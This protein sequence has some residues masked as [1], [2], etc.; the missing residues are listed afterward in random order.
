ERNYEASGSL[1]SSLDH[2]SLSTSSL[3]PSGLLMIDDTPDS[4]IHS[5]PTSQQRDMREI[6][7]SARTAAKPQITLRS[8]STLKSLVKSTNQTKHS[9]E[10][11]IQR[12][13]PSFMVPSSAV[14]HIRNQSSTEKSTL[15]QLMS[16]LPPSVHTSQDNRL[17]VKGNDSDFPLFQMISPSFPNKTG[18][19]SVH[20][21]L[22]TQE[23][24]ASNFP[25]LTTITTTTASTTTTTTTQPTSVTQLT[26]TTSTTTITTLKPTRTIAPTVAPKWPTSSQRIRTSPLRTT[27][28]TT[29]SS[30][31]NCNITDRMWVKTVLSIHIRRN[32]LD[33]ILKQNLL[34]G[35]TLALTK[36]LNDSGV[37]PQIESMSTVPNVTMGYYVIRG[38]MV[39]ITSVVVEALS[40]YGMDRLMAD[41]RQFVP[42]LQAV[43]IPA[44]PWR[45]NPAISLMLKTVLRF[46]GPGDD[47]RSCRFVQLM[48][49]RLENAFAE[50]QAKVMNS[51]STLSVQV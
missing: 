46:V 36:A 16:S 9:P 25:Q 11:S 31:L 8:G 5:D 22:L 35:L 37:R 13:E 7:L 38:D 19:T 14:V 42:I 41:I 33:N 29:Q 15:D 6:S 2:G 47:L 50:A 30:P 1:V 17:H 48:E 28:T 23:L 39:Y 32:R 44:A 20:L 12:A 24:P 10:R 45:P 27:T 3:R 40:S 43:P 18:N 21:E 4:V 34:K 26:S 49:E 51:Y